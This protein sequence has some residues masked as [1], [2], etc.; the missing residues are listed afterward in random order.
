VAGVDAAA[1]KD[2]LLGIKDADPNTAYLKA[3]AV[4]HKAEDPHESAVVPFANYKATR[5]G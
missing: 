4:M 3:L 1:V 5:H 2:Q